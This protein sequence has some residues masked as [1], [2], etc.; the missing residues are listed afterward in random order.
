MPLLR[1]GV[2]NDVRREEHRRGGHAG[3][4]QEQE[5][6]AGAVFVGGV[7]RVLQFRD[8]RLLPD[9]FHYETSIKSALNL[10]D[11]RSA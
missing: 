8:G 10:T 9:D 3:A 2:R 4:N 11:R 1:R 6:R 5:G 7:T